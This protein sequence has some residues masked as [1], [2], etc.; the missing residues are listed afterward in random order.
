MIDSTVYIVEDDP[1]NRALL[2]ALMDSVGLPNQSFDSAQ[3][4]LGSFNYTPASLGCLLLDIRMPGMSGLELQKELLTRAVELPII[5]ITGHG[6]TQTAV[7]AMKDGAFDYVEKP[8]NNQRLLDIV[9]KALTQCRETLEARAERSTVRRL[10]DSLTP[11]EKDVLEQIIDGQLNKQIAY[12]LD[13]SLRTVEVHR[14]RVM[15]KMQ[16]GSVADL[17][18]KVLNARG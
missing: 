4:F 7:Q 9:N 8:I 11:R 5:F 17:T 6:E 18:K 3:K 10:L 1:A 2:E 15:E 13:I 16:A 14:A 12:N